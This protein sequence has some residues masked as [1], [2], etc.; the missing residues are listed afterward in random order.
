MTPDSM[1][2]LL[3]MK[4]GTLQALGKNPN[5]LSNTGGTRLKHRFK[6]L[7]LRG[8]AAQAATPDLSSAAS[9]ESGNDT[10]S[11]S[12]FACPDL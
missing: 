1:Y 4:D 2:I 9:C 6:N 5:V 12:G 11:G 7:T 10:G 3:G 8:R